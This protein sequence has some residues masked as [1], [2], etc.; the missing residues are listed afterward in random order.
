MFPWFHIK[1]FPQMDFCSDFFRAPLL[2][3]FLFPKS[4]V[5]V[6][7][8]VVKQLHPP[9]S[10]EPVPQ[11]FDP[12]SKSSTRQGRLL[13]GGA[14]CLLASLAL[15]AGLSLSERSAAQELA[16]KSLAAFSP[17]GAPLGTNDDEKQ[18][19]AEAQTQV[20][21]N[22]ADAYA[23][24]AFLQIALQDPTDA[25][26]LKSR[27][28]GFSVSLSQV[29]STEVRALYQE[30][31][32]PAIHDSNDPVALREA[33]Q[34]MDRWSIAGTLG[35]SESDSLAGQLVEKMLKTEDAEAIEPLANGVELIANQ[36]QPE[37]YGRYGVETRPT[38]RGGNEFQRQ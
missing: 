21:L 16:A 17:E 1:T 4:R 7:S 22:R 27:E 35:A 28:Q 32:L 18:A 31:I 8:A 5:R 19:A 10:T 2:D 37:R 33:F 12:D 20:E 34:L 26:R 25:R 11:S 14:V 36:C 9:A 30:V 3:R 6:H 23:R 38:K 13:I 15:W 29:K 24:R